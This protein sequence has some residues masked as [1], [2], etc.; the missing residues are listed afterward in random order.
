MADDSSRP[1]KR[2]RQACEG[3]RYAAVE[4]APAPSF[5]RILN[6]FR[7]KKTRCPG[8]QPA[9]SLCV[10]LGQ[11]C[12]YNEGTSHGIKIQDSDQSVVSVIKSNPP[13]RTLISVQSE[14]LRS[15]ESKMDLMLNANLFVSPDCSYRGRG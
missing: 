7:R 11:V 9:C 1:P 6:P 15:L 3:C 2:T 14:R 5:D 4:R 12:S 13:W 8:E 10:R